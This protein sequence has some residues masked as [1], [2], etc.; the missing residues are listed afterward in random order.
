M[1]PAERVAFQTRTKPSMSIPYARYAGIGL[2]ALGL[3]GLLLGDEPLFGLINIDIAEDIVH[4]V[5]GGI[6][7]YV[8]FTQRD[9]LLAQRYVAAFGVIYLLV[10]LIGFVAPFF[11]EYCR[12]GT[13]RLII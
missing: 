7:A 1:T 10:G 4:L 11:S 6:L 12:M 2:L 5:T 3:A 13:A 8:G 9:E